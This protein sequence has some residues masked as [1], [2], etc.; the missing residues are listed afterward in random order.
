MLGPMAYYVA[1]KTSCFIATFA[2]VAAGQGVRLT[3]L[4][5]ETEC[6][7][8]FAKTFDISDE[9]ITEGIAFRLDVQS[10]NAN[11]TELQKLIEVAKERCPAIYSMSHQIKVDAEIK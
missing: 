2:T 11:R 5:V 7:I 3:K 6:S 1:G 4:A 10:D 8:N 9:P